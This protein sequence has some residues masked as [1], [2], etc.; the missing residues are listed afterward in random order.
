MVMIFLANEPPQYIVVLL[1][2]GK[3]GDMV[4]I[5]FFQIDF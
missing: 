5:N 1:N 4:H 2:G 3:T